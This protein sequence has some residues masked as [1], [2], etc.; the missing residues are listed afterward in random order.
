MVR[1]CRGSRRPDFK[2]NF[3]ELLDFYKPA[4]VVFIET[5]QEDHQSLPQEFQSSNIIAVPRTGRA[6]GIAIL[7]HE[8]ILTG[9]AVGLTP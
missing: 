1:N 3:R 9:S 6:G 2:R 5:H 7:W 4:L 8:D